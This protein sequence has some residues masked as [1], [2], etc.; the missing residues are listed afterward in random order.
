MK[1]VRVY[2]GD[3]DVNCDSSSETWGESNCKYIYIYIFNSLQES[4]SGVE[5]SRQGFL[6]LHIFNF[7]FIFL[8][9][10]FFRIPALLFQ[11]SYSL[12]SN[13]ACL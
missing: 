2:K 5:W 13:E 10:S 6:W 7:L 4:R 8:S 3:S 12:V 1:F 11:L 9:F